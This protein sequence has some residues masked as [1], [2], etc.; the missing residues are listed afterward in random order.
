MRF[1]VLALM[2]LGLFLAVP[3]AAESITVKIC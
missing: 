3:A 2:C 1:K